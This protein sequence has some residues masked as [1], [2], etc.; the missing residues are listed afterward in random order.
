MNIKMLTILA[1]GALL[2]PSLMIAD[3]D[4]AEGFTIT[5][6]TGREFEFDG[7]CDRV[8]FNGLGVALTIASAGQLDKVVAVDTY[9]TYEKSKNEALKDLKAVDLG[10]F[11][12]ASNHD[13]IYTGLVNL[14][15]EGRMSLDDPI[16]LTSYS[17]N[18]DLRE[19][20][21]GAGFKRVM[22]WNTS[23]VGTY[24]DIV[25]FVK[26]VTQIVTGEIGEVAN[27]MQEKVDNVK[28]TASEAE[29]RPKALSVWYS[30]TSGLQINNVG[31]ASSMLDVC[32]AENIGYKDDGST[33]Y[34]DENAVISILGDNPGATVFVSNSWATAGYTAD[35]FRQEYLRGNADI[36]VVVMGPQWNN[37]CPQSAD[38]LVE[39]SEALYNPEIVT[40]SESNSG[41]TNYIMW[42]AIIIVAIIIAV[43]AYM[44]TKRSHQ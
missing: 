29:E 26:N 19:K 11:Y 40:P 10:S 14:V 3:V 31:I 22:I 6:D 38:G 1:I 36:N 23:S 5:D 37:Y 44:L 27:R 16:I 35:D 34:G 24:D 9:S 8:A 15:D 25:S 21:E 41:G 33:R 28:K 7:A 32:G 13:K 4:A 39:M 42:V 20:L 17:A 12:Y 43:V 18:L 30:P 2:I